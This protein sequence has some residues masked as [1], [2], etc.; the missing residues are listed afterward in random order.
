VF[1]GVDGE[2]ED[3]AAKVS[4]A[5]AVGRTAKEHIVAEEGIGEEL[6]MNLVGWR[7]P[8][9]KVVGQM[10][11]TWPDHNDEKQK[12]WR[13]ASAAAAMR[14]G[15]GCDSFTLLCEGWLSSDPE[16]SRGRDLA[17]AF[18]EDQTGRITECLSVLHVEDGGEQIH[19]CGLPFHV[20]SRKRISWGTLLHSEGKEMLRNNAYIDSLVD[21]L[22]IKLVDFEDM[23]STR[24]KIS[25]GLSDQAGF[26]LNWEFKVD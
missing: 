8:Y 17:R 12:V 25:M 13:V 6:T 21:A 26:F 20:K 10:D 9:L 23:E 16:Y 19:V 11:I 18:A 22:N 14:Q 5:V 1:I 15:W 3:S 2:Y 24:L 7:G 4:F